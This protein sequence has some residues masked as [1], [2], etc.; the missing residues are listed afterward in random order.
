ME[1]FHYLKKMKVVDLKEFHRKHEN[2]LRHSEN[3]S[4]E[5]PVINLKLKLGPV[6]LRTEGDEVDRK[7][8]GR[9]VKALNKHTTPDNL[10]KKKEEWRFISIQVR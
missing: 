6:G 1:E 9:S 5:R 7:P 3:S 10:S 2:S 4:R 8:I